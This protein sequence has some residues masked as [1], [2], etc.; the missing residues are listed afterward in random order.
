LSGLQAI[1]VRVHL[2]GKTLIGM[3]MRCLRIG[4]FILTL[5]L[6]APQVAQGQ[7]RPRVIIDQVQIGFPKGLEQG[8][9]PDERDR[10]ATFKAGFWT[11]VYVYCTA[12]PEGITSG[13]VVVQA[14]DTDDVQNNYTVPLPAGGVPPN[15]PFM[16]MAYTKPGS[17][18]GDLLITV[19]ADD[20]NYEIKKSYNA[21]TPGDAF[22]L[23][24]GSRLPE[25]RRT[26]GNPALEANV[27]NTYNHTQV[28]FVDRDM[29]QLP[30]RW[31]GYEGV[32]LLI[33]TTGK[34]EYVTELLNERDGRKEALSNWVRRGGR[35]VLSAGRNQDMLSELLRRLQMDLPL[36]VKEPLHLA[37]LDS[38]Q[39]WLPAGTPPLANVTS[40]GSAPG[41]PVPI[42]VA[43]LEKKSGREWE[44]IVPS[45]ES[46]LSPPLIVRVP[47]GLGQVV[48]VAF[49]LDMPPF[50]GW[51][52]QGDFW[53][54]LQEKTRTKPA[55][56]IQG[57]ATRFGGYD[58][59]SVNDVAAHLQR[60]LEHFPD[61][62]VISFGWVALFILI[63]IVV[64]GPVDYFFLKKVVKRLELTWIT[65]P[66]IVLVVSAAAYYAAYSLK[67]NDLK[68][69]KVDVVDIDTRANRTYGTSWF[70][71]FSP[72][73]QLY[74]I[75]LEPTYGI[76]R[77]TGDAEDKHDGT[78]MSWMGRP[79]IGYGGYN[80]A[81]AQ[82]LFRRTY[83]YE[84]DAVGLKGVPIQVWSTKSFSASWEQSTDPAKPLLSADLRRPD[85]SA[86]VQGSIT[87]NLPVALHDV[88][89][90][91]GD[92][93]GESGVKVYA[94]GTMEPGVSK[95]LGTTGGGTLGPWLVDAS[96]PR[97]VGQPYFAQ[98]QAATVFNPNSLVKKI[99]FF[100]VTNHQDGVRDTALHALDQSWRRLNKGEALLVGRLAVSDGAAESVATGPGTPSRLWLGQMPRASEKRPTLAGTLSQRTY[101]RG[102]LS[103]RNE[104]AATVPSRP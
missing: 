46:D 16:V 97:A 81:H 12:G 89:L 74:T 91:A 38:V 43:K 55:E 63:Y 85:G 4:C 98:V 71:L 52:G 95:N 93:H 94:I 77:S 30:N 61:V 84:P 101:V 92:G 24:V 26:L 41:K 87:N 19:Q 60:E 32:D 10:L 76:P 28:A 51:R 6:V 96:G 88:A 80:R 53:K 15:E 59:E 29:S 103:V 27:T 50:S 8:D 66:T 90:I 79:D 64:V 45:R 3:F 35:L 49:D 72:R 5:A 7:A 48:L 33:L 67:G 13:Q 9:V 23:G 42:E 62:S 104:A 1:A 18:G 102:Y 82:S 57:P 20:H 34:R 2:D 73:I 36:D 54:R 56:S 75:G 44:L 14:T 17:A 37:S 100:D 69:N 40:K 31:F 70:T 68:I 78:V 65:F 83:D 99:M 39:A 58:P 11:P 22:Y 25:L 86:G 47:H 21:V